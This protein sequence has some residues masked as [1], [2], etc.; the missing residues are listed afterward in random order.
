MGLDSVELVMAFEEAFAVE[1]PD[2]AAEKML[3]PRDVVDF[4]YLTRGS[5]TKA[6][7]L[8][9]RAFH[10]IRQRLIGEGHPRSEIRVEARLPAFFPRND[11]RE[12]WKRMRGDFTAQQW[13]NLVRPKWL[14]YFLIGAVLIS[15][16]ALAYSLVDSNA[17]LLALVF[18]IVFG[19]FAA[20]A[21]QRFAIEFPPRLAIVADLSKTVSIGTK[22]LLLPDEELDRESISQIVKQIVLDQLG[23]PEADYAEDKQF[24]RDFGIG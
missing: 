16:I 11:R 22:C 24:V 7:C 1:I 5:T 12:K 9:R 19:I 18:A 15:A 3:T 21:T 6:P 17:P 8:T 13:P 2:A 4:V 20:R 14:T 23:L 10:Q